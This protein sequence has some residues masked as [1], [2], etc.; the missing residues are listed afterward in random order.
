MSIYDIFKEDFRERL[1]CPNETN[2]QKL[3]QRMT[4]WRQG[5]EGKKEGIN[6]GNGEEMGKEQRATIAGMDQCQE[7]Q[8]KSQEKMPI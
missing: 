8:A 5:K 2:G 7:Q 3:S 1:D 4:T 6:A